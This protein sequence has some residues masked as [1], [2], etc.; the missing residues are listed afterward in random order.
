[1]KYK[2]RLKVF[3]LDLAWYLF[4]TLC[5][6][7]LHVVSSCSLGEPFVCLAGGMEQVQCVF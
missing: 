4:S 6:V 7:A 2:P 5:F 1:M 3:S